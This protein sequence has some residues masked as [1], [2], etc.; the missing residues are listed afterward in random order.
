MQAFVDYLSVTL[1][2]GFTYHDWREYAVQPV[3]NPDTG[4][5][6]GCKVPKSSYKTDVIYKHVVLSVWGKDSL[7]LA[8]LA[9]HHQLEPTRLDIKLDI[10][11]SE[12][13]NVESLQQELVA[14]TIRALKA[15]KSRRKHH[16]HVGPAKDGTPCRTDYFGGRDS[17]SQIRIYGRQ[18][19][20]Y[21][22][23]CVR[24]E[25]QLRG[26]LAKSAWAILVRGFFKQ[27]RLQDVL[28]SLEAQILMPGT[29]GISWENERIYELDRTKDKPPSSREAW[30]ITQVL[31]A[32]IKEF[33]ETGNN[34]AELVLAEFNK[35]F[36]TGMQETIDWQAEKEQANK[37][38]RVQHFKD[39]LEE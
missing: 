22:P 38:A 29:F 23:A 2:E 7:E 18:A 25:F 21:S 26:E 1:N 11:E 9:L 35:H 34:L 33:K 3:F 4:L 17:D 5:I 14:E 31:P 10:P 30:A 36:L 39:I 20:N 6:D 37:A 12:I 28:A 24:V 27:S 19:A 15:K 8:Y 16:Y 32:F 13:D